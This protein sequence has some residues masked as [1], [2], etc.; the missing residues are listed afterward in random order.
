[1]VA[2]VEGTSDAFE[3][4][5]ARGAE[6]YLAVGTVNALGQV[7]EGSF[8]LPPFVSSKGERFGFTLRFTEPDSMVLVTGSTTYTLVRALGDP[9][10]SMD[11]LRASFERLRGAT[12][13]RNETEAIKALRSISTAQTAFRERDLDRDGVLAY[14]TLEALARAGAIDAELGRG[15]KS[16]YRFECRPGAA[17]PEFLWM[18]T[19]TALEL[20]VTGPRHFVTNHTC[21]IY[22]SRTTAF[23][24]GDPTAK[25]P[26]GATPV[27]K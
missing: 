11:L 19:A 21:V 2:P 5:L 6:V 3:G 24:L 10:Q 27:G 22:Y 13:L 15:V 9:A 12:R 23:E 7:F 20:G 14:G 17:A 25:I 4:I 26:A 1:M 8:A 16:G 18:A